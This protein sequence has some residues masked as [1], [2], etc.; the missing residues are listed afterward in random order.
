MS[1]DP[2]GGTAKLELE[3]E[4]IRRA[5][6][7]LPTGTTIGVL[8][9]NDGQ[10][11]AVPWTTIG[12]A[13][14]QADRRA[15]LVAVDAITADGG[16]ELPAALTAAVNTIQ[17]DVTASVKHIVLL[18]D[19]KWRSGSEQV[20]RQLL[21]GAVQ[22]GIVLSTIAFGDDADTGTMQLL[23]ELGHGRYHRVVR[24]EDIPTLTIHRDAM[25]VTEPAATPQAAGAE[26][27]DRSR[28]IHFWLWRSGTWTMAAPPSGSA[29]SG[30]A[31]H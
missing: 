2:L 31:G 1:Y 19:G 7:A 5:V 26:G 24:P 14:S 28:T 8:A 27:R 21:T 30:G 15:I 3:K 25:S 22:D 29:I 10:E 12:A 11:W 20:Y 23:A 9:F 13:T 16:S 18:S 17:T 6:A 4:T